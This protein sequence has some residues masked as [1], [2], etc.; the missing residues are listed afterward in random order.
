MQYILVGKNKARSRSRS[1]DAAKGGAEVR[2]ARE[3]VLA[4]PELQRKTGGKLTAQKGQDVPKFDTVA[5]AMKTGELSKPVETP[6]YGWFVIKAIAGQAGE[7]DDREG[8]RRDDP[9]DAAPAAE[10]RRD[11]RLGRAT[12]RRTSART[13]R[14]RTR[15]ATRRTPTPARQYTTADDDDTG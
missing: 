1:D 6:E 2:R 4:G 3:E 10:E 8:R 7:D 12:S 14:S 5:F 13:G 15:S 9:A 11:D